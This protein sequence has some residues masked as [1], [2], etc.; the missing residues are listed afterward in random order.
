MAIPQILN[1]D[2]LTI[3]VP[4]DTPYYAYYFLP[5]IPTNLSMGKFDHNN[6]LIFKFIGYNSDGEDPYSDGI[7]YN[8][9][10]PTPPPTVPPQPP[11]FVVG[12][13]IK[14]LTDG[15]INGT[16][17]DIGPR[18]VTYSITVEAITVNGSITSSITKTFQLTLVG[19]IDDTVT[20]VTPSNLGTIDNGAISDFN[21]KATFGQGVVG[22]YRL[23]SGTLPPGL[24]VLNDGSISGR[25]EFKLNTASP[26]TFAIEA[27]NPTYP[28][29]ITST[30][31]FTIVVNQVY[32]KP[33]DTIYIKGLLT[34]PD[35]DKIKGLL[36]D[37]TA[38]KADKI[39]RPTDPYFG[40]AKD[41][42]YQHQYGVPSV[43]AEFI[44]TYNNTILVPLG[45]TVITLGVVSGIEIG[46]IL[47]SVSFLQPNTFITAVDT[48][49]KSVTIDKPTILQAPIDTVFTTNAPGNPNYFY[50]QYEAALRQSFYWRYITL[51]PLATAVAKDSAENIIYEV[52][53]SQIIDNLVT[54]NGTSIARK[55]G[56]PNAVIS[57][58]GPYW[59]S[60][61]TIYTSNTYFDLTPLTKALVAAA[62]STATISLNNVTDLVIGMQVTGFPGV[63]I[64]NAGDGTPP[65]ITAIN[66]S[67]NTISL[68]VPQTIVNKAQLI[69]NE[70]IVTSNTDTTDGSVELYPNSLPNMREEI[71]EMVG[72]LPTANLLP[73]WMTSQQPNGSVLGYVPAWVICYTKPDDSANVLSS[74]NS[75]LSS[76]DLT[77]NQI[78]FELDRIEV[79]RSMSYTWGTTAFDAWPPI[80]PPA[81]SSVSVDNNSQDSFINFP[82]KTIL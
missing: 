68:S 6:Q 67:L 31:T 1:N 36:D 69:F 41:V 46:Q 37:I 24:E 52:V 7:T 29:T 5:P 16:L 15:W 17:N 32:A 63:T 19:D 10:D 2:P 49:T 74:M 9:S 22:L 55:I 14:N 12:S 73:T 33:Y 56:F 76:N 72:Q 43:S 82:R 62:T 64:T 8:I 30:R 38:T 66:T 71:E 50:D 28:A 53:Y 21:V 51:G 23:Q 54:D 79:D 77:L 4:L 25:V 27:Y 45:S 13:Q 44:P 18:I 26:Y 35:R 3:P 81:T 58:T 48:I 60:W 34:R 61:E 40:V 70:P 39:Y 59:T 75:Y 42:V 65:I 78:G 57:V 80:L 20:W 47:Q 11:M